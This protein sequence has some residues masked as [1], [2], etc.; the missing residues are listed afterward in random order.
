MANWIDTHTH[1]GMLEDDAEVA[2]KNALDAGVYKFIN[3]GT[4]PEDHE[5]VYKFA[6]KHYPTVF[7]TLGVH[8]HDAKLYSPEVESYLRTQA[9]QKEVIAIGEIGLDYYYNLSEKETQLL[10]FEK[11][12]QVASDLNLPVEIHTRDAEEDTINILKKYSGKVT[13]LLHC[14]TGTWWCAD[15]AIKLG[16]NISISG[17]V[18]FKNATELQDVVRKVPLDRLHIETDAPFL[19]PVPQRGKKNQPAFVTHTASFVANLKGVS[20]KELSQQLLKNTQK[21]FKKFV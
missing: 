3:I 6:Q 11:Q 18:T 17:I 4:N 2:L 8:P 7:C 5:S 10:A 14:F 20:E 15:E 19:A 21:L 16:Y 13:G 1:F 12:M 9:Q